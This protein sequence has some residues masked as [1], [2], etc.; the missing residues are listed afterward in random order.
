MIYGVGVPRR[1]GYFSLTDEC[2][3]TESGLLA[4]QAILSHVVVVRCE[5]LFAEQRFVYHAWCATWEEV[6]LGAQLPEYV[7]SIDMV[8]E[9]VT[10]ERRL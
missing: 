2:Y 5:H 7:P 1:Y 10:W 8:Q 9:T 4:V 6:V 3:T